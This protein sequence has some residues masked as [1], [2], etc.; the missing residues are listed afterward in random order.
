MSK[1][2]LDATFLAAIS[3][4]NHEDFSKAQKCLAEQKIKGAEFYTSPLAIDE[5]WLV[6]KR[7]KDLQDGNLRFMRLLNNYIKRIKLKI[8]INEINYSFKDVI[9]D[10]KTATSKILKLIGIVQLNGNMQLSIMNAL[11]LISEHALRPRD[12]FH[13]T[14]VNDNNIAGIITKDSKINKLKIK[15]LSIISY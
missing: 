13:L 4:P 5:M 8:L 10:L 9:N 3:I 14:I 12:S 1:I 7:Y 11:N 2:Y 6:V 15:G